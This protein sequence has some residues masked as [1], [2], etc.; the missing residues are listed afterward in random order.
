MD[1]NSPNYAPDFL[2]QN[3]Q[4]VNGNDMGPAGGAG[5][6][7]SGRAVADSG[8]FQADWSPLLGSTAAVNRFQ[9]SVGGSPYVDVDLSTIVVPN[10]DVTTATDIQT[11]I[12]N[13]FTNKGILGVTVSVSFPLSATSTTRRMRIAPGGATGDVYIR[14]GT[15]LGTQKDL[16]VPLMLGTAQGGLEVSGNADRRPAPNGIT[17]RAADPANFNDFADLVQ[18]TLTTVTLDALQPNGTFTPVVINL[19][20]PLPLPSVV[21]VATPGVSLA[22]R[23]RRR[24][25]GEAGDHRRVDQCISTRRSARLPMDSGGLGIAPGDSAVERAGR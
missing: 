3:S 2:T 15:Q 25:A 8:N 7:L 12:Q 24:R 19:Q 17:F 6:S 10:S 13:A 1:P 11:A 22:Q 20:M 18:T 5:F 23:K 21:T 14:P 4:L 16:A 9:V